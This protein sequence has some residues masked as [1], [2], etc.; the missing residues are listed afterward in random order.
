MYFPFI[1]YSQTHK[2]IHHGCLVIFELTSQLLSVIVFH[3]GEETMVYRGGV[4]KSD[5]GEV[6]RGSEDGYTVNKLFEEIVARNEQLIEELSV[7]RLVLRTNS[8]TM[9]K[10]YNDNKPKETPTV[11]ISLTPTK[12]T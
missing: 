7:N 3:A 10:S 9:S 6:N 5:L 12:L 4:K 2:L 1:N 11:T 8:Q